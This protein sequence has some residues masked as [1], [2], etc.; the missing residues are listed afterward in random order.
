MAL[1]IAAYTANVYCLSAK[2]IAE[3]A[4]ASKS[5]VYKRRQQLK[6]PSSLIRSARDLVRETGRPIAYPAKVDEAWCA[7]VMDK[8][9]AVALRLTEKQCLNT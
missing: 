4:S 6:E 7:W 8:N 5:C 3:V 2:E 1:L 9:I